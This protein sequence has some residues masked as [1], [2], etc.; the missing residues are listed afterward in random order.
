VKRA[1]LNID[2]LRQQAKSILPR[3]AFSCVARTIAQLGCTSVGQLGP[4]LLRPQR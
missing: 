4:H 2:D 3:F 1:V